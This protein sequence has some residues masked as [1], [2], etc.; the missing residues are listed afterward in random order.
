MSWTCV[1]KWL[2]ITDPTLNFKICLLISRNAWGKPRSKTKTLI[3]I[4]VFVEAIFTVYICLLYIV[5]MRSYKVQHGSEG[6]SDRTLHKSLI[7]SFL[8]HLYSRNTMHYYAY[9]RL[10]AHT[11]INSWSL[12]LDLCLHLLPSL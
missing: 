2:A 3:L 4:S 6:P 12:S 11:Y 7:T 9:T 10:R 1:K 5:I 8:Y